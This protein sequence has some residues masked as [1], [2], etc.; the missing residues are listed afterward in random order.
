MVLII[1]TYA[2]KFFYCSFDNELDVGCFKWNLI[3]GC[4]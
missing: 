2:K 1:F 3:M 4:I